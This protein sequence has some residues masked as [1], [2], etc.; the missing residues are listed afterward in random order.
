LAID[1]L[2]Y[3]T[4]FETLEEI[5]SSLVN[6]MDKN[7][8]DKYVNDMLGNLQSKWKSQLLGCKSDELAMSKSKKEMK[9]DL[10]SGQKVSGINVE[11]R[12]PIPTKSCSPSKYPLYISQAQNE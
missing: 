10:Y 4:G 1:S 8:E 5:S 6:E 2:S 3:E 11:L 12:Q 7:E 9:N